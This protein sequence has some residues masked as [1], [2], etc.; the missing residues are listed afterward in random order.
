MPHSLASDSLAPHSPPALS[1]TARAVGALALREMATRYGR[2][3]GGYI[4][5]VLEPAAGIAFLCV[6]FQAGFRAPPLGQSFALFYATGVLPFFAFTTTTLAVAQA[7]NRSRPLMAYP[8]VSFL[9]AL[10]A[11]FLL[12]ALTQM[13]VAALLLGGI[14]LWLV[15]EARLLPGPLAL[16]YAMTLA[17][18]FGVGAVLAG[19]ITRHP[20]WHS[21]W[22]VATRPLILVS[23]VIL[24]QD[25]LPDPWRSWLEWNPLTHV[26]GAARA[27][28]YPGYDAPYLD[29]L[30]VFAVAGGLAMMG[31]MFLRG[32][33]RDI[34]ER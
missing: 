4:W 14:A 32:F 5:A 26:T 3:P 27:A 21:I 16:C 22:S 28:F 19:P 23:G 11:S 13:L 9:D 30:Y 24:L 17:L 7:L 2:N 6:V 33:H 29:P 20:I 18:G 34:L 8:R 31:L 12:S 1:T 25:R 10:V 15:P